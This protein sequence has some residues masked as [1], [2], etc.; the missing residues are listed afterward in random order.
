MKL[1]KELQEKINK[2]LEVKLDLKK[3]LDQVNAM[4]LMNQ[5]INQKLQEELAKNDGFRDEMK[6]YAKNLKSKKVEMD[7]ELD[8]LKLRYEGVMLQKMIEDE[9]KELEM[10]CQTHKRLEQTLEKQLTGLSK[11]PSILPLSQLADE[12]R[13][14]PEENIKDLNGKIASTEGEI[15]SIIRELDKKVAML[16]DF[17]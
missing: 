16:Q 10:F 13:L 17:Q 9:E 6:T 3:N 5:D 8:D 1:W 11:F 14:K 15:Q 12:L 4:V 2:R 7:E